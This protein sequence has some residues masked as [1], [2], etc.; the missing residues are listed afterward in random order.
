MRVLGVNWGRALAVLAVL[1]TLAALGGGASAQPVL[2]LRVVGGLDGV[3]QFTRHE[4]PFWSQTLARLSG[5]RYSAEIVPFDRAGIRAPELLSMVRLGT[6]PFANVLV[7]VAAPKDA[8]LG[9]VDIAGLN[10][11]IET[12]RRTVAAYRPRLQEL[13]RE[14]HNAEL[15]AV[16]TYPAQV[17]F[18]NK[19]IAGLGGL[20]GLR[21]RT[22]S[23]TQAD[24]VQALG[25]QPLGV[26]FAAIVSN[27]KAGNVDCAIT[28][29]MSGNTI[30]LHE[31]T[32]HVHAAA[33]SWGVG[34]FVAHGPTWQALPAELRQLL[35]RE[36]PRLEAAIWDEAGRETEEG[37]ACNSGRAGCATG[38]PGRMTLIRPGPADEALRRDL[39]ASTVV[40]N[41]L[42]RCGGSCEAQWNRRLAPLVG[43]V[44]RQTPGN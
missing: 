14:R 40:P 43:V 12:L 19:P 13:L 39:L 28:G 16:Y 4:A 23:V 21:V 32:T 2:Q 33:V 35:E 20:K 27:L 10:P 31:I 29:T 44:A 17:L 1:A 5:G 25:G 38:K 41:W 22:S 18:C 9:A 3:N 8:E 26:P 42:Q 15:L 7:G 34:V 11:D 30:G 6:V 24:W 37:L 36:L